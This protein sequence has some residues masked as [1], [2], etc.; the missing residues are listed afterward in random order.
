MIEVGIFW[1]VTSVLVAI[2]ANARGRS[3][4]GYFAMS[5]LLSPLITC[6]FVMC[7]PKLDREAERQ[8]KVNE[9]NELDRR[10]REPE[11][12]DT[13]RSNDRKWTIALFISVAALVLVLTR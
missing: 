3:G 9:A 11:D 1:L 2:I 5:I 13:R 7:M 4:L 10:I 8:R 12:L 6:I